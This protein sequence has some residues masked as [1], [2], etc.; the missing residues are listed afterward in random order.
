MEEELRL[1]KFK[2]CEEQKKKTFSCSKWMSQ[3]M[4]C[5]NQ[6]NSTTVLKKKSLYNKG[7]GTKKKRGKMNR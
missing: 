1:L 2:S 5:N 3:E 6:I 4:K 7:E